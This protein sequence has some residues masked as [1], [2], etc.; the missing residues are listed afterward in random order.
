MMQNV[1]NE[2]FSVFVDPAFLVSP[3]LSTNFM[4]VKG[5]VVMKVIKLSCCIFQSDRQRADFLRVITQV[6]YL[7]IVTGLALLYSCTVL[8][9][10]CF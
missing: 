6:F 3:F 8:C 1:S 4:K 2:C 5:W 7:A 10:Y 9:D